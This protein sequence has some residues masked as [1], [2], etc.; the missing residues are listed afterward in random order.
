MFTRHACRIGRRGATQAAALAALAC[1]GCAAPP[2]QP[3]ATRESLQRL[4]AAARTDIW[5]RG[6]PLGSL[7]AARAV[8]YFFRTDC[9][10]CA[11]DLAKARALAAKPSSP[12]LVLVSREGSAH[13]RAALGR[14]RPAHLVVL[15]DSDGALMDTALVTRFVPRVVAVAGFRV[16][17]DR[18]GRG[19]PGLE[20]A[21]AL[22]ARARSQGRG[23]GPAR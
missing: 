21:L 18:T 4:A 14:R 8:L 23:R 5:G 7:L 20:G 10:F 1:A 15:S 19:G 9:E 17:L 3:P 16:L 6:A 13:L 11:T 12:A 22:A 2:V